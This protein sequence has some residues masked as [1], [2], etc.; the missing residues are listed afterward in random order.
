[1]LLSLEKHFLGMETMVTAVLLPPLLVNITILFK[2]ITLCLFPEEKKKR[3][4][5]TS[6]FV[7]YWVSFL[8]P[9]CRPWSPA[10]AGTR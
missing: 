7:G 10:K 1:M 2:V 6:L 3:R 9:R 8:S 4:V 5:C